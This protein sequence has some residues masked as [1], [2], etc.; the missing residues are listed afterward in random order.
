MV[1]VGHNE[2]G[3]INPEP[4]LGI[5]VVEVLC[6]LIAIFRTTTGNGDVLGRTIS[7]DELQI[8]FEVGGLLQ[9]PA[10]NV[11]HILEHA[12]QRVCRLDAKVEFEERRL[13]KC[14]HEHFRFSRFFLQQNRGLAEFIEFQDQVQVVVLTVGIPA[15][16]DITVSLLSRE[17]LIEFIRSGIGP[18]CIGIFIEEADLETGVAEIDHRVVVG[19]HADIFE[20]AGYLECIL[21][22]DEVIGLERPL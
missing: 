2:I 11:V 12:V 5:Q 17:K 15:H 4:E 10:V 3:A 6:D 8:H 21:V 9:K 20:S 16:Q 7:V 19:I 22:G 14:I 1:Q 18:I 13:P